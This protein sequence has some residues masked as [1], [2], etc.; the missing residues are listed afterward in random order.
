MGWRSTK[1][2]EATVGR[3]RLGHAAVLREGAALTRG[4]ASASVKWSSAGTRVTDAAT[5]KTTV[6][7]AAIASPVRKRDRGTHM[8]ASAMNTVAPAKTTARPDVVVAAT[9]LSRTGRPA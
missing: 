7:A 6:M 2:D 1:A 5:E 4:S 8:P 3:R 9:M